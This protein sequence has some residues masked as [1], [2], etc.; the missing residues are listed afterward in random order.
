MFIKSICKRKVVTIE[1][2]ATLALASQIMQSNHVGSI[3]VTENING[4]CMPCGIITD[5]DITLALGSSSRPQN[6]RVENI[7]MSQPITAFCSDGVFEVIL[8]MRENGIKRLPIVND[9]NSL[10]GIVSA[11]DL[12]GVLGEEI[13]NLAKIGESQ[14]RREEGVRMPMEKSYS[15]VMC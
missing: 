7:M 2:S 11:D 15:I 14:V 10:Y 12:L 4:K 3:V 8:K 13:N 5:R 1:K 6:I 9:D